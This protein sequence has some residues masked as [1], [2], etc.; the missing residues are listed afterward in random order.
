[1]HTRMRDRNAAR[2]SEKKGYKNSKNR[3]ESD[4]E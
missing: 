4:N 1:M 2:Y 3:S